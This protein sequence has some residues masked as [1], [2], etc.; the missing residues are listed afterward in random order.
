LVNCRKDSA[1]SPERVL[2]VKKGD[3]R[4]VVMSTAKEEDVCNHVKVV[5]RV[6]P[7]SQKEK[8]GNFSKVVHVVDQHILVFDPKEEEVSFFHGKRLTNRDINKRMKKDLKFI[9]DAV[10]AE[11]SSQLEVFEHTTKSVIDGF[12]NG[13]NCTGNICYLYSSIQKFH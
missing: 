12:L 8:D 1:A 11:D 2:E 13:Y 5:V 3:K 10:F 7:E 6:R 9:F 4:D